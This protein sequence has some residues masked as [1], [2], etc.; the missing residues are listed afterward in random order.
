MIQAI[1]IDDEMPALRLLDTILQELGTVTICGSF[2][3][4]RQAFAFLAQQQV[5]VAFLDIEMPG[6]NGLELASMITDQYPQIRIVYVTAY[7][8][9][10]VDA[11]YLNALDYIVK[12]FSAERIR[13]TIDRL[14]PATL[15]PQG[16]STI[17]ITCFGKFTLSDGWNEIRL[18]TRKAEE[19]IA[20]LIN[21]KGEYV[22][23]DEILDVL[24]ENFDGDRALVNFNT[25]L[26][27]AKSKLRYYSQENLFEFD[28]GCYRFK[29][30]QIKCDYIQFTETVI[31]S[32]PPDNETLANLKFAASLYKGRYLANVD[33]PWVLTRQQALEEKYIQMI[34][35]LD[36]YY[37]HTQQLKD[38]QAILHEGLATCPL[39]GELNYRLIAS[40]TLSGNVQMAKEVY[41]N[42][43]RN[44][45]YWG[46]SRPN[47]RFIAD[48]PFLRK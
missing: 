33:Y 2:L 24:W 17:E 36:K 37:R 11:F 25:T 32:D 40:F 43:C 4:F 31:P 5:D 19:L 39:N 35:F 45:E 9:Y 42:Y 12:P 27:Y 1:L 46:K 10:A 14:L 34:V 44:L 29:V 23:R 20:Y 22:N 30:D 28:R 47:P 41:Q 6:V 18:R 7:N 48:F 21:A 26:Y 13:R 15:H 3:D 8:Q 16:P 38:S